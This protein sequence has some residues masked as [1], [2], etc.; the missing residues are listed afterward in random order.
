MEKPQNKYIAV[1]YRLYTVENNESE[2]IE[3]TSQ[4]RPF[5]FISG[6][7]VT[8]ESFEKHIA[9]LEKG[10]DF[11]FTL[12][13]DE[14]YGDYEPGRVLDLERGMFC[15]NG[16]FDHEHIFKD[17]IVPLQ[18]EDGNRFYG[19]VLE[20]GADTVK[21]DLNHPLA[22]KTLNFKGKVV[23]N[24]DATN[25]EIQGMINRLSGEGCGC[26]CDSCG[27]GCDDGCHGDHGHCDCGCH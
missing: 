20:V 27:G 3:E 22:G 21:M 4:D 13:K 12:T 5:L 18:N 26:G 2:L 17:A 10:S 8:L 15:I 19:R 1:T 14:A 9:G 16:H 6:F 24:R 23:E 25:E 7:G 11:D